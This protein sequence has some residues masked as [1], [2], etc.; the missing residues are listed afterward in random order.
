MIFIIK[1]KIEINAHKDSQTYNLDINTDIH[2]K[3]E[4][5][6]QILGAIF[7]PTETKIEILKVDPLCFNKPSHRFLIYENI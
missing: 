2:K 3:V 5:N 4:L 1:I 6:M 7:R